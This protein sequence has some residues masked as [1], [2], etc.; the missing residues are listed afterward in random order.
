MT[1][2]QRSEEQARVRFCRDAGSSGRQRHSL[3]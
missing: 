1:A 3:G 2:D